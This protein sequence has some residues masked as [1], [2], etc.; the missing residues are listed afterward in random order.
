MNASLDLDRFRNAMRLTASGVAVITTAGTGGQAGL[1]VSSLSSLSMDPP[2]VIFCV[3]KDARALAVLLENGVFAANI[4]AQEQSRV[5]DAFAGLIPELREDRFA[6]SPWHS[7]LTGAPAL[8]G[9]MCTFDCRIATTFSFGTHVILVG[10]VV[11]LR[12]SDTGPLVFS[13]KRYCKLA[14]M[15][16]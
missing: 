8:D 13:G 7:L 9:A 2:S 6:V 10:E 5:A 16:G 4:L 12:T 1:T 11:D 15:E 3:H 14:E